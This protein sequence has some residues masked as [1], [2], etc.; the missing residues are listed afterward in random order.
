MSHHNLPRTIQCELSSSLT[1]YQ[2]LVQQI[3]DVLTELEWQKKDLFGVHLALEESISNAIRH[4]NKEDP[5]KRVHVECQLSPDRFWA[6]VCDEGDGYDPS[7]VPDC[8]CSENIEATGGRGLALIR[9][10]MT[11]VELSQCG[12]CLTMEKVIAD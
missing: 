3:L 10:Y 7:E 12:N 2:E 11:S 9:A 8:R 4:G 1:A 6:K 5:A